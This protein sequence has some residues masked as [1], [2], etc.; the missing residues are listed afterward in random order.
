MKHSQ[1]DQILSAL[2]RRETV[3]PLV[4]FKRWGVLALHS[5]CSELRQRGHAIVC[6]LVTRNG[7]RVG[8]YSLRGSLKGAR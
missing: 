3:T 7:K 1:N 6:E 4:A 2:K 5:R 8:R